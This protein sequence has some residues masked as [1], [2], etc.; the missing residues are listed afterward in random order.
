MKTH[1][2]LQQLLL[3]A[4]L[5]SGMAST[6]FAGNT[7]TGGGATGNW[8]DVNNWGGAI[9]MT[10]NPNSSN[11]DLYSTVIE[12][13]GAPNTQHYYKYVIQP[14]TQWE[15]VSA[16]NNIGGNRW[17][18]L[19]RTGQTSAVLTPLKGT[20]PARAVLLAMLVR[21]MVALGTAAPE[22]SFT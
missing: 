19:N 3:I 11:P 10:N 16:P 7:W 4:A 13:T 18:D 21:V 17:F 6:A 15:N 12:Y 2:T 22:E 8:S 5:S 1:K 9:T 20:F 14:G